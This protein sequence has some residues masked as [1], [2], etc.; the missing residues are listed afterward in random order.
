M[1]HHIT[2]ILNN[3]SDYFPVYSA[4]NGCAIYKLNKF[5]DCKYDGVTQKYF[6]DD[7]INKMITFIK[8]EY[9][10]LWGKRLGNI[11]TP[12][13]LKE[14]CE[15]IGFHLQAISKHNAKIM[16]SPDYLFE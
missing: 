15:H 9:F 12:V 10:R 5:T 7:R 4:F 16:I 13:L 2:D 14:N 6:D 8:D 3:T 11:L 1:K